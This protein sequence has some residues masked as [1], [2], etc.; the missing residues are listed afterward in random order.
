MRGLPEDADPQITM[1]AEDLL[2]PTPKIEKIFSIKLP[3]EK[4][5][6]AGKMTEGEFKLLLD[7]VLCPTFNLIPSP[8]A[9]NIALEREMKQLLREQYRILDFLEDQETAVVNGAAG[10]GKTMLAVEK[11]RRHS[12]NDEKVLFLCYNRMLCD[13]LIEDYTKNKDK[14]FREQYRNVDFKTISPL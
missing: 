1:L 9:L 4:F 13:S 2:N 12:E 11:A 8:K 14:S 7:S 5:S 6:S 3:W 10:T